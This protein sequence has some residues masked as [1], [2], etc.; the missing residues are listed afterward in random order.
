MSVRNLAYV[1][2]EYI[3]KLPNWTR[4][5]GSSQRASTVAA[6]SM[7]SGRH[8]FSLTQVTPSPNAAGGSIN[9]LPSG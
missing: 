4:K 9:A 5:A 8:L 7:C 2:V 6:G 3:I 1:N